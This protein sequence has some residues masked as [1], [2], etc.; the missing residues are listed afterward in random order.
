VIGASVPF[1]LLRLW[2][3]FLFVNSA[4]CR[5]K[6]EQTMDGSAG[7]ANTSIVQVVFI[8]LPVMVRLLTNC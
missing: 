2:A 5:Q 6:E 1:L 8:L 7:T 3:K 4:K